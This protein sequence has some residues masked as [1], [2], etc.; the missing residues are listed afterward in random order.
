MN[1]TR[2]GTWTL[3][4]ELT[5][6]IIT[7]FFDQPRFDSTALVMGKLPDGA[8]NTWLYTA[9]LFYPISLTDYDKFKRA[10][11]LRGGGYSMELCEFVVEEV[12]ANGNI[13]LNYWRRVKDD[14][15][16][17]GRIILANTNGSWGQVKALSVWDSRPVRE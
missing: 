14:T 3:S 7:T 12:L 11:K 9:R 8:V 16:E 15:G 1:M 4:D 6:Y 13:R 10:A 2:L 5:H 17:G